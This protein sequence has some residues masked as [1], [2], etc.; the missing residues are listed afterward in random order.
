MSD[1]IARRPD[2]SPGSYRWLPPADARVQRRP[3]A[4]LIAAVLAFEAAVVHLVGTLLVVLLLPT[5]GVPTGAGA[6]ALLLGPLLA[7]CVLAGL[8]LAGGLAVIRGTGRTLL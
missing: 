4:A 3:A 6:R 5:R 1:V 8:I 7:D 2:T